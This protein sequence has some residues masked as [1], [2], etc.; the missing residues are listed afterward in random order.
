MQ[1]ILRFRVYV[2]ICLAVVLISAAVIFSALRAV[3]PYATGYKNEIQQEISQQIGLPVK[4][5]TIDAEIHWFSPRLKLIDV[6]VYDEKSVTTLLDFDEA[7]VELDIVASI[8]RNEIIVDAVG[9]IGVDLSIEKFSDDEWV[10]QGVKFTNEGSSELPEKFLYMLKN[11][12]Y[13]LHDSNINFQDHTGIAL[14]INLEDVNIDVKNNFNN[15]DV[16]ISLLLPEAYGRDLAVVASLD[17]DMNS[18]V[19]DIYI[20]AHQL[21]INQWNKKF[22]LT[23]E[24]QVNAIVDVEFWTTLDDGNIDTLIASFVAENFSIKNNAT[25]V[26]WE[27][28]FLST[29]VRYINEDGHWN[30]AV[31]DL[32]FGERVDPD[33]KE[34]INMIASDD[35]E[36]YYFGADFLR[37]SDAQNISSVF[38]SEGML[39]DLNKLQSYDVRSDIYNLNLKLP[40]EKSSQALMNDIVVDA[41]V[42]DFSIRDDKNSVRISG[43][44]ASIQYDKH[45][46]IFDIVSENT[47]I[48]I[49]GLFAEPLITDVIQGE[50]VTRY[51]DGEW[52]FNIEQLKIKNNHLDTTTR[53]DVKFSSLDDVFVDA[54]INFYNTD[55]SNVKR[56]FPIAIMP[57]TLVSWL[58]M[59]ITDGHVPDGVF[60]FHGK[61]NEFPFVDSNGAF[62]VLFSPE[63][64]N[65]VFRKDWPSLKDASAVVKFN[66]RSLVVK[67]IQGKTS[68]VSFL[69]S[70]VVIADL[71]DPHLTVTVNAESKVEDF[72]SYI[73]SSPLDKVL[74]E[75]MRLFQFEGTSNLQLELGLPLNREDIKPLIN[76]RMNFV[77]SEIYYPALGYEVKNIYGVID[78]TQDSIFSDSLKAKVQGEEV[79]ISATTQEG[80]SGR[81]VAFSIDGKLSTDYLLQKFDWIPKEWAED[82]SRWRMDIEVPY[83]S[84]EYLVHVE[85]NTD[86]EGVTFQLSDKV[87]KDVASKLNFTA[88]IDVL[89]ENG[90]H[91]SATASSDDEVENVAVTSEMVL[92]NDAEVEALFEVF[93][94]RDENKVWGFNIESEYVTGR[95]QFEEGLAKDTQ[96]KLDLKNIDLHALFISNDRDETYKVLPSDVPP[97]D[98]QANRVSWNNLIFTDVKLSTDWHKHG[99]LINQFSLNGPAMN[100]D[101][102]GTWLTSWRGLHETVL[103]GTIKG[104]NLGK[105]LAGL[106]FEKSIARS[107]Y[108]TKFNAKWL[109]EPYAL[110]WENVKGK[111]LFTME[112]GQILEVDPGAGGRLLGLLNIFKLA[113]RLVF[114]FND[115]TREGFSFDSIDG[116]FVFDYG[117]GSLKKFDVSAPAADINMFGDIGLIDRD[118]DLLMRVKPHTDTLT[119]AGGALL[120]G[121]AVGAGLALLQKVFDIGVIVHNVYTIKGGWDEPEVEKIIERT[122]DI[123]S[124]IG[125]NEEDDF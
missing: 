23:D 88:T 55:A 26:S 94:L 101:A 91:I 99:M 78:F 117:D 1:W 118:Y 16:K 76:G 120:G 8:F 2:I 47:E 51:N 29:N 74:G 111:S 50:L 22:S 112:K 54:Q 57:K 38:L 39:A 32:Y 86:F 27:T 5:G 66:N 124:D 80:D 72:Q 119:F 114:D 17:G 46:G 65:M 108:K 28:D 3:L 25:K 69:D 102:R 67:D 68:N 21:N 4:I 10:V 81:E 84:S 123:D 125:I 92:D 113:N 7:F 42:F 89:D 18:L 115:I 40:K 97:L 13:L 49:A 79:L 121:V 31:S 82:K 19:G 53:L 64:V 96:I 106:G 52:N 20:E 44:D 45:Q 58:D 105:T 63:N 24:Y 12:D 9:L 48:E 90:L 59:A 34:T 61:I 109:A 6:V 71:M 11:S 87:Q 30:V 15:H 36:S 122:Q 37:F 98:L 62:Q 70:S 75:S 73:W 56:Y 110:S 116:E 103:E 77:N 104:G 93:A 33:R 85:A 107:K 95:L 100:F 35:D 41:T 60:M 14:N 83:Q 43:L